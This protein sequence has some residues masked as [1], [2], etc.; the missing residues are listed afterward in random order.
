MEKVVETNNRGVQYFMNNKMDKAEAE[1]K[2]ALDLDAKNATA[3][4]NLGL[5][6]HKQKKYEK[7]EEYFT[8]A[9]SVVEKDTYFLNLANAQ[10]FLKKMN[11]A[12][13]NYK[14]SIDINGENTSAQISLAR[15]YEVNQRIN[16]SVE[17]W[18][19][20]AQKYPD[21]FYK[22]ELAKNYMALGNFELALAVLEQH[23]RP[24]NNFEVFCYVG[25]CEFN[26][27]NYG[28][29]EEAFKKSLA[30]QPDDFKTRHYLAINYLSQGDYN[31]AIKELDFLIKLY[32]ENEKV[33][34]DKISV[35]LNLKKISDAREMLNELLQI[36]PKNKKALQYKSMLKNNVKPE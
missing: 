4:N 5:L 30:I 21:D 16:A 22:I 10:V 8:K 2:K 1:Y 26:L 11:E 27:K 31:Q 14:K 18:V 20:L 28:L 24:D 34:L 12:E 6:Y 13:I 32:P 23:S 9:I 35:L 17:I 7:A 25:V 19:H 29:A 3:L 15:F 36:N 33:R